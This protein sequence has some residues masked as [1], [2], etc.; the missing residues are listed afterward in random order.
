[1][2]HIA[3]RH[4]VWIVF[5]CI[6]LKPKPSCQMLTPL[7][8]IAKLSYHRVSSYIVVLNIRRLFV[9]CSKCSKQTKLQSISN[10]L[11]S[12]Y[13][14]FHIVQFNSLCLWPSLC[15]IMKVWPESVHPSFGVYI[16]KVLS[17]VLQPEREENTF[18]PSNES[19]V[20][21]KWCYI[22]VDYQ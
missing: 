8:K 20:L 1:M 4:T 13:I 19:I 18:M 9:Y 21:K 6:Y 7:K 2:S 12:I 14:F 10:Y 22:Y 16:V 15:Q 11:P 5:V 17:H 3:W